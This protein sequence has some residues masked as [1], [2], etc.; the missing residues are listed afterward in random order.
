MPIYLAAI[1]PKNLELAGEKCDG[2][3]GIFYDAEFAPELHASINAGKAKAGREDVAF[4]TIPT[5]PVIVGDDLQAC[6]DPMRGYA[7][8]YIGGMGSREQN[9]Y[10]RLACRMGFEKEAGEVQD[11]FLDKKYAEAG[12]AIPFD[13]LDRTALIGPVERIAEGMQKLAAS[14]VTTVNVSTSGATQDERIATIR[15]AA[16]A[17]EKSGVGD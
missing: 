7:S 14:G 3:L 11:L 4:D 1:G 12:A 16:E 6:A 9:F 5:V 17:L 13:F 15:S 8:L 10:N 2:W